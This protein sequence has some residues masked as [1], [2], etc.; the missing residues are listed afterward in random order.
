MSEPLEWFKSSYSDS[1]GGACLEVAYTWRKS[2]YSSTGG[3]AC[4]EVASCPHTIHLRDSK[5]GARSPRFAVPADAWTSFIA[6][7][8]G[9]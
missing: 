6:Y 7:A 2:S 8:A 5:L 3:G 4:L 1:Q 9:A